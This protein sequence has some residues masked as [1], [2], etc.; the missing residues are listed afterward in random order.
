M[1]NYGPFSE[2]QLQA[3]A[4]I[5]HFLGGLSVMGSTFI[6]QDILKDPTKRK[7]TY[8]RI[9]GASF[10]DVLTSFAYFLSSWP[11]P[12]GS[13]PAYSSRTTGTCTFQGFLETLEIAG[14]M[15]NLGLALYHLLILVY[16]WSERQ[17]RHFETALKPVSTLLR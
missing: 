15:Y 10:I 9:L 4:I 6:I 13:A 5:P 1:P 7:R 12:K 14:T 17:L 8:S 3:L 2:S 11:I 16:K